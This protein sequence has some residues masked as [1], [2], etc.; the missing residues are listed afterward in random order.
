RKDLVVAAAGDNA[1]LVLRQQ[2]DGSLAAVPVATLACPAAPGRVA[3]RDV[4]VDGRLDVAATTAAGVT[5][6]WNDGGPSGLS[7]SAVSL[8]ANGGATGPAVFLDAANHVAVLSATRPALT[9]WQRSG[10]RSFFTP[11]E[12]ALPVGGTAVVAGQFNLEA[13]AD[14]LVQLGP[15]A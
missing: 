9:S 7:F 11:V 3:L 1:V 2:A 13:P 5:L 15:A 4:D 12:A 14:A 10:G 8:S 6:F